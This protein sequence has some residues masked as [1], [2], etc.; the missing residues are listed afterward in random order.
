V[1]HILMARSDSEAQGVTAGWGLKQAWSKDAIRIGYWA[2]GRWTRGA[3]DRED[4]IQAYLDADIAPASP[5][6][7]ASVGQGVNEAH[8]RC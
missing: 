6:W 1:L 5:I 4:R 8:N 3:N 7:R 2:Y